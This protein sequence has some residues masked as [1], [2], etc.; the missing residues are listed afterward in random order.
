[1]TDNGP[2][3]SGVAL[4]VVLVAIG[5]A[6]KFSRGG[7]WPDS[8]TAPTLPLVGSDD[9]P[10]DPTK[11]GLPETKPTLDDDDSDGGGG[12]WVPRAAAS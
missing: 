2:T 3:S 9:F 8:F 5:D 4:N 6:C 1:L 12:S 7:R 10:P 11:A